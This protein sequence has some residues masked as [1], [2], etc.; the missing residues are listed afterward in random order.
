M[1]KLL[2]KTCNYSLNWLVAATLLHF[3]SC[4]FGRLRKCSLGLEGSG[5]YFSVCRN[6]WS[7]VTFKAVEY[8][9]ECYVRFNA[10]MLVLNEIMNLRLVG[11]LS[12]KWIIWWM[13]LYTW[14]NQKVVKLTKWS[15]LDYR[16]VQGWDRNPCKW[17][18]EGMGSDWSQGWS[19]CPSAD[20]DGCFE[21]MR[22][23]PV[24][25]ILGG[26]LLAC[27]GSSTCPGSPHPWMH[28][29]GSVCVWS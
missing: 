4:A 13:N 26:R 20:D 28:Q 1:A 11:F 7:N 6:V 15:S 10:I 12:L 16:F 19:R 5:S 22:H 27:P 14:H 25:G 3:F 18:L 23:S 8:S 21:S 29:A 17:D 2:T 9:C 24:L